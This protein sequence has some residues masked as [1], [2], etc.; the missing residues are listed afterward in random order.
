MKRRTA[1]TGQAK[2]RARACV[3]LALAGT[4]VSIGVQ[5]APGRVPRR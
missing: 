3:A 1:I 5:D 4:A 2:I